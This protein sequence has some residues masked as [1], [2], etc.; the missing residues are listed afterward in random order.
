MQGS[1][2]LERVNDSVQKLDDE[3]R[4]HL[5]LDDRD[6]VDPMPEHTDKVVMGCGYHR[7]DVLR[8]SGAFLRLKEVVAHGAADH[9]LPV[10]LQENVSGGVH[11]E[12]AVDHVG[13]RLRGERQRE[14]TK[15]FQMRRGRDKVNSIVRKCQQNLPVCSALV[16]CIAPLF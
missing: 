14:K 12:Q 9:A 8:L 5:T 16:S 6:K 1:T 10:L 15:A 13:W 7:R 4:R 3:Q 11:E 2:N